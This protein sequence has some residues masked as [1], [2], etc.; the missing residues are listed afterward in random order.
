MLSDCLAGIRVLDLSH[1]IPGPFATQWLADLGADVVK[2]EPP[3]GD[4]MRT[5]GPVDA[6]GTTAFY[7]LANRNKT[8]LRLDLK[9]EAGRARF[10][11]LARNAD[12]LLEA[13]RPGAMER[14]GLDHPRLAALNPRLIHCSLSGYGQT[15]PLARRAGHDLTYIALSGILARCG[16]AERPVVP[17]PPLAD[18]AGAMLTVIAILGALIGRGRTGRGAHL[19]VSLTEAAQLWMGGIMTMAARWG[20]PAREGDLINGGAA[21]YRAYAT[22]DGRFV[23]LAALE[24]KFWTAFC[25]GVGRPD[26]IARHREPLPQTALAADLESLFATRDRDDWVAALAEADCCLEPVLE[27]DEVPAHPQ[28]LARGF[29]H[30]HPDGMVEVLLPI[31]MDGTRAAPRHPV[32]DGD[33]ETVAAAWRSR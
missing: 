7:K 9:T 21:F 33:P 20:V 2:I 32:V 28:S 23:A 15:G 13:Y 27:A 29:V 1:Y 30:S 19:D 31:L 17:H 11:D 4:P 26:W 25:Q 3:T 6:D 22:Q 24:E 8:V 18:H 12:V 16:T 14:L 10:E 5:M